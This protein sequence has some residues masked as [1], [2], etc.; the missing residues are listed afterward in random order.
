M[1]PLNGGCDSDAI[2]SGVS[3]PIYPRFFFCTPCTQATSRFH[4]CINL[5][6]VH[7]GACLK[8][9]HSAIIC[10]QPLYISESFPF[11]A[12]APVPSRTGRCGITVRWIRM[13]MLN[14][15]WGPG[16]R[17]LEGTK[18]GHCRPLCR[19]WSV[20]QSICVCVC[21]H[22]YVY[23]YICIHRPSTDARQTNG[24][25]HKW[26]MACSKL[27]IEP[28]D[29]SQCAAALFL[30]Q[31]Q[32]CA[33]CPAK[34]LQAARQPAT[35]RPKTKRRAAAGRVLSVEDSASPNSREDVVWHRLPWKTEHGFATDTETAVL[36]SWCYPSNF[37]KDSVSS[38]CSKICQATCSD[39]SQPRTSWSTW[40]HH[41]S[42]D[43]SPWA[44]SR[45]LKLQ[46][47]VQKWRMNPWIHGILTREIDHQPMEFAWFA[48]FPL[49][50]HK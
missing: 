37:Q 1:I 29:I 13:V 15:S 6:R 50:V 40:L 23:I 4:R 38:T 43:G 36:S 21:I 22:L 34:M 49:N 47:A 48:A 35:L 32:D 42:N 45:C 44:K 9:L 11:G 19:C 16:P 31:R 39:P 30:T 8:L 14:T 24:M 3:N 25:F 26:C 18:S 10:D 28:K 12:V 46:D 2:A 17:I 27:S 41:A 5:L 7:S 33:G 20:Q